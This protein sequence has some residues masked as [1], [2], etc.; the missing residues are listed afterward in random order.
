MSEDAT[1]LEDKARIDEL[2]SAPAHWYNNPKV[3]RRFA[4]LGAGFGALLFVYMKYH[5]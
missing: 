1:D 4:M 3:V 2:F 5:S